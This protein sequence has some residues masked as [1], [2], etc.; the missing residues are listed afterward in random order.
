VNSMA[1][2]PILRMIRSLVEDQRVKDV[3]DHELLRRFSRARDEAAFLGLLRRHGPMVLHVCRGVLGQEADA[4]DAFQATFLVLAQKAGTI[5]KIASV[6]SWLHGVAYRTALKAQA[7]RAKRRKHEGHPPG[8]K[9]SEGSDD[10]TWREVRQVIH[11]E[12]SGVSEPYQTPLVLCY[13]EGKTQDEAARTLGVSKATV[14]NRLE[15]G[16]AL[17]RARLERRGL[18]AVAVLAAA[19]WPAAG[20][21]GVPTSLEWSTV[22]AAS[23]LAAGQAATAGVVSAKVAALTEGVLKMMLFTK[24]RVTCAALLAAAV[25]GTGFGLLSLQGQAADGKGRAGERPPAPQPRLLAVQDPPAR[26]AAGQPP[27]PPAPRP[28][29][30]K[31]SDKLQGIWTGSV[32]EIGGDSAGPDP[33]ALPKA[34]LYIKGDQ[35]TLRGPFYGSK[36][37]GFGDPYDTTFTFK[38]DTSKSPKRLDLTELPD[39]DEIAPTTCLCIY[40]LEGDSLKVC[41]TTPN[42]KRPADFKTK[43][44]S[45]Q[46]LLEVKRDPNQKWEKLPALLLE[47]QKKPGNKPAPKDPIPVGGK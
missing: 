27:D 36:G 3:P 1:A 35:L 26:A 11:A 18:G 7:E 6:G 14:K 30:E 4:E 20:S 45:S 12:L 44:H 43:A 5:R 32:A 24:L 47:P 19:A 23:A 38:L 2:S 15:R 46:M 13:L 42:R 39:P 33:S 25:L 40:A 31:D 9:E 22:K 16:R 29:V 8:Q 28:A 10:L 21:A 34:Q 17:L 37:V 41:L